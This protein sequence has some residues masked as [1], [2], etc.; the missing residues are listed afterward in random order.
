MVERRAAAAIAEAELPGRLIPGETL[1]GGDRGH[2]IHA[3]DPR[4]GGGLGGQRRAIEHAVGGMGDDGVGHA[5]FADEG[6]QRPR[7]D[8]AEADDAAGL[9]PG[10]EV[11]RRPVVGGRGD[12]GMHDHPAQTRRGRHIDRLDIL[13]VG[14]DIADMREGER[15][16][17]AGIGGIGEDF[18][19]AGHRRVETDFA[20]RVSGGAEAEAFDDGPVGENEEAGRH[21]RAPAGAARAG[22]AGLFLEWS[23]SALY[24]LHLLAAG[25]A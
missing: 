12:G 24:T 6:G 15:D 19:V 17:L 2:Q 18:L 9:Q 20:D 3:V 22:H 7:V 8:A 23:S 25:L 14:A 5:V 13:L 10:I 16:D 11:P 1:G 4:P 21:R